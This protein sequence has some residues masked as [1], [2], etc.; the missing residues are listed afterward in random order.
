MRKTF[1]AAIV[2]VVMLAASVSAEAVQYR[3]VDLGYL[4]SS[5]LIIASS[6]SNKN[7][8]VGYSYPGSPPSDSRYHAC[9]LM[10]RWTSR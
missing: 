3:I 7:E 5:F 8:V 9:M 10:A 2:A 4:P 1:R 6:I